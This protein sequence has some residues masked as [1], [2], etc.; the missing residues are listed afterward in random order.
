[1]SPY[2]AKFSL[3]HSAA[4]ALLDGAVGFGAFEADAR[5][6][7]GNLASMVEVRAD[8]HYSR[9]Y[10]ASWGAE[11]AVT[12]KGGERV[13]ARRQHCKG[14]PEAALGRD[15]MIA[16]S[17]EL[18]TF[19]GVADTGRIIDGVLAMANGGPLPELALWD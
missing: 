15:D 10:P 13:A 19:G 7:A 18:L 3:Q 2:E 11:V 14:D 16:K 4:I 1:M 8:D 12:L 5:K 6:R 17:R 9:A